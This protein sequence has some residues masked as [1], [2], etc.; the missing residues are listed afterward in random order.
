MAS[1]RKLSRREFLKLYSATFGFLLPPGSDLERPQFTKTLAAGRLLNPET[2]AFDSEPFDITGINYYS[3]NFDWHYTG[4]INSELV[5]VPMSH[6]MITEGYPFPNILTRPNLGIRVDETWAMDYAKGCG[7]GRV[8]IR[9][10][11]NQ[12]EVANSSFELALAAAEKNGLPVTAVLD[13]NHPWPD[14]DLRDLITKFCLSHSKLN[15]IVEGLNEWDDLNAW[16]WENRDPVTAAHFMAVVIDTIKKVHWKIGIN[17]SFLIG[18]TLDAAKVTSLLAALAAEKAPLSDYRIKLAAHFYPNLSVDPTL[19]G[20]KN[21]VWYIANE[22]SKI[23]GRYPKIHIT[24]TGLASNILQKWRLLDLFA[25]CF[26]QPGVEAVYLHEL[27]NHTEGH[28]L[29]VNFGLLESNGLAAPAYY[30]LSALARRG[31]YIA[32]ANPDVTSAQNKP[33]PSSTVTPKNTPIP[34]K[35]ISGK[36]RGE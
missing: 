3:A 7:A 8:R 19:E 31:L 9:A 22:F 28:P 4:L 18:S 5:R 17:T 26:Q 36:P 24:E 13:T 23:V 2:G 12:I 1:G 11:E 32:P 30:G 14:D 25:F 20:I 35:K 10:V 29:D 33:T 21:G 16:R 15:L 34:P 6:V 27:V